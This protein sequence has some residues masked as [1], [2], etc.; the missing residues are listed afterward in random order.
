M[1]H[2]ELQH[3]MAGLSA[4]N[5]ADGCVRADVPVRFAPPL[6]SAVMPGSRVAGRALPAR[7][8]G[9][10]DIFLEAFE[11]AEPGDVLVAD[12]GGR[13]DEACIGDLVVIEA[14][15]AGIAGIVI[16]G[17]HRDTADIK[18]IGLPVFS[19]GSVP[20]GP[21]RADLRPADALSSARIGNWSL[22]SDDLVIADDDGVLFLPADRASEVLELAESIR[23]TES[24]QAR[25]VSLGVTLRAQLSFGE[26]LERRAQTPS[27]T[28]RD[29]LRTRGGAIEE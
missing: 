1:D 12:N 11:R 2:D 22:T 26:Y 24:E 25:R 4:A 27:L 13:L 15:A 19:L 3:R 8:T 5:V 23:E 21:Q 7:H 20:A 10:V 17:L 29:H 9:S 6:L 14:R 18:A 16:W 28:F